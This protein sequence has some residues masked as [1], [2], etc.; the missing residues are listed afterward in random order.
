MKLALIGPPQ[1]GKSTLF[2]AITAHPVDPARL[3]QE[4]TAVVHVPDSRLAWLAEQYHPERVVEAQMEFIDFP[5]FSLETAQQQAEFRRHLPNL[6]LCNGLVAVVRAFE[7][8]SVPAYRGRIDPAGDLAELHSELIFADLEGVT[9]H[10]DKLTR[11]VAKPTPTRDHDK[12]ELALFE[13]C[14]ES[15]EKEQALATVAQTQEEAGML[16]SFAFLTDKPLVSAINVSEDRA[17]A[18]PP[19]E[20][21]HAKATIALCA[22]TEAEIAQLDEADRKAFLDDLGVAEPAGARLI[23]A[24]YRALGLISFL[25]YAH[26]EVRAWPVPAGTNAIEAAGEVHTDMARGFIRAETI[27]YEHLAAAGDMKTA[28]AAGKVRQEGK[29][30]VVQDGDVILFRFNV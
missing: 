9:N 18:E 8:A 12:R 24:C 23:Q 3:A 19:F 15:L 11:K 1:S 7:S 5:G 25:T 30:Y 16:R 2:S 10:I 13:R 14:R 20:H 28:K 29:N 6:R 21:E 26:D 22:E 17:A 4:Q 27:G